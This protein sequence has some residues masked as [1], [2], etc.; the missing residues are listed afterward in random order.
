MKYYILS[1]N[2]SNGADK[3][4]YKGQVLISFPIHRPRYYSEVGDGLWIGVTK[5]IT[6]AGKQERHL[7]KRKLALSWASAAIFKVFR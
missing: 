5:T 3:D 2:T 6:V 1:G 4:K 7:S